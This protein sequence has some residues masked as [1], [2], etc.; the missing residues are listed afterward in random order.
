[1]VWTVA[2]AGGASRT[3]A[4]T[5]PAVTTLVSVLPITDSYLPLW[6][7]TVKPLHWRHWRTTWL[8]G[9]VSCFDQAYALGHRDEIAS[10]Y[11]VLASRL[12]F[13]QSIGVPSSHRVR[14]ADGQNGNR[15]C[16]Q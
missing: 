5:A 14:F 16:E 4:S 2:P 15:F 3:A 9:S 8:P 12:G 1:M 6:N 13:V 11:G 10:L 7:V